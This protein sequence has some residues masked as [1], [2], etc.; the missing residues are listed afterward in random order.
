MRPIFTFA[1]VLLASGAIATPYEG[2]YLPL[3]YY[4]GAS[5]CRD[6]GEP[7]GITSIRGDTLRM[8]EMPCVLSAPEPVRGMEA[9]LYDALCTYSDGVSQ[10]EGRVMLMQAPG[11]LWVIWDGY[12]EH[13]M[14]CD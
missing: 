8:I 5:S 7:Q 9:T 11:E 4:P 12:I 6:A 1:A 13:W 2:N 3:N 10:T 14:R